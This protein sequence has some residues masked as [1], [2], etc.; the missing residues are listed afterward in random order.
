[1][2]LVLGREKKKAIGCMVG[3]SPINSAWV[4]KYNGWSEK[5]KILGTSETTAG[6]E[7]HFEK[8]TGQMC[9]RK[10]VCEIAEMVGRFSV[11]SGGWG[12]VKRLKLCP[13]KRRL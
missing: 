1:V 8:N 13:K 6:T 5:T 11:A 7:G 10:I 2:F 4:K 3:L 9:K 12:K